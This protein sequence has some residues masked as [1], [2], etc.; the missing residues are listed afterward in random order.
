MYVMY[1]SIDDYRCI[2]T[3]IDVCHYVT[4]SLCH[5]VM[6]VVQVLWNGV[7]WRGMVAVGISSFFILDCLR[8][9]MLI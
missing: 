3:F 6:Y 4:M 8:Q 2:Y 1:I 5:Y 7:E 9:Q